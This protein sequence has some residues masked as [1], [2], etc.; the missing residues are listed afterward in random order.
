MALAQVQVLAQVQAL[1]LARVLVRGP[2]LGL[3][4]AQ[5]P[6]EEVVPAAPEMMAVANRK[7]LLHPRS[8]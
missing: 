3:G 8:L 2:G 1:A 4:L 7:N 5:G 6:A